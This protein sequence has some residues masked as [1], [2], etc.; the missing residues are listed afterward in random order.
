[1]DMGGGTKGGGYQLKVQISTV[2]DQQYGGDIL[3]PGRKE[4]L[5]FIPC[6]V[7]LADGAH[8]GRTFETWVLCYMISFK[9]T[10]LLGCSFFSN[11]A[12]GKPVLSSTNSFAG[13]R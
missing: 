13:L 1:M 4:A 2:F 9:S 6:N 8:N 3:M 12:K 11:G 10:D 7:E 5:K